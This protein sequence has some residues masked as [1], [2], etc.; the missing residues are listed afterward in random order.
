MRHAL[1]TAVSFVLAV[2]APQTVAGQMFCHPDATPP[3]VTVGTPVATF[4]LQDSPITHTSTVT[5][6]C[7]QR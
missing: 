1:F 7:R 2:A 4:E 6:A 3:K 5:E